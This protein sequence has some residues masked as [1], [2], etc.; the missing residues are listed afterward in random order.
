ML[1]LDVYPELNNGS[2]TNKVP[3]H[4]YYKQ[5]KGKYNST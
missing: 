3:S 2:N 4:L 1:V 5:E